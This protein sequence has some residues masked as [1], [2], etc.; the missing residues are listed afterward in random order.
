[1]AES[2]KPRALALAGVAA[3]VAS[4]GDLLL[5]WVGNAQRAELGLPTPPGVALSLGGIAGVLAIPLYALGYRAV[6]DAA[7]ASAP[8]LART[9]ALG[10]LGMGVI[11]AGIHGLTTLVIRAGLATGATGAPPLES[12]G[13]QPLLVWTWLGAALCLIAASAAIVAASVARV[14]ALPAALGL[15]NPLALTLVLALA[16]VPTEWGRSFLLP[17]APNLAHVVFFALAHRALGGSHRG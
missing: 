2:Y 1:M 13:D 9:I 11:G 10:G 4:A 16:G 6:A 8:R 15:A 14:R 7:R 5:L 12:A 17:A 3:L